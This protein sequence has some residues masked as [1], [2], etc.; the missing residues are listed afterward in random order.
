M[1]AFETNP[2]LGRALLRVLAAGAN[3]LVPTTGLDCVKLLTHWYAKISTTETKSLKAF[4]TLVNVMQ[5][6][7]SSKVLST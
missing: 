2:L 3:T 7:S 5:Q 1:S 6:L 4:K